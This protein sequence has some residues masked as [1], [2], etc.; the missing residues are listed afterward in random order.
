MNPDNILSEPTDELKKVLVTDAETSGT[1][2]LKHGLLSI[3]AAWI[4]NPEKQFY[5]ECRLDDDREITEKSLGINGFTSDQCRD[6]K[7]PSVIEAVQAYFNWVESTTPCPIGQ[8]IFAGEN[9]QFD[10]G[11]ITYHQFP[12]VL[13]WP[14]S[15]RL[16]D[17]H[18]VAFGR[19]FLSLR[20][21]E[22]CKALL[23]KPEPCPHH[24]LTGALS[25]VAIFRKLFM[26]DRMHDMVGA[27]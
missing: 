11:F 2:P 15:Y 5:I 27:K 20:H 23:L 25:E 17:M 18:S 6:K 24:A 7:K 14:F 22:I 3:G 13:D 1:D 12:K 10:R 19:F 4:T 21:S 8:V 16:L 26:L 9:P